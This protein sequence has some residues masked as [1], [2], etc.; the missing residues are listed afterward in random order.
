[1]ALA[2]A[3]R[4]N[5]DG[6]G[7]YSNFE[8][9]A[10]KTVLRR[11]LSKWGELSIE[12]NNITN[13]DESPSVLQQRDDEFSEAKEIV[14]VDASTGEINKEEISTDMDPMPQ[15]NMNSDKFKLE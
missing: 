11:L 12:S 1:M 15:A 4:G 5:A 14:T 8:S 2:Q 7:W 10:I 6:V 9:M 3:E 13:I